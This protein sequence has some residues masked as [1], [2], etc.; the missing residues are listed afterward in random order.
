MD[1]FNISN[2]DLYNGLINAR[3]LIYDMQV[4]TRQENDLLDENKILTSKASFAKD[5]KDL[6][7]NTPGKI[8]IFIY[9]LFAATTL[10]SDHTLVYKITTV[11]LNG[12][13]IFA[14]LATYLYL[15]KGKVSKASTSFELS[16]MRSNQIKSE[17]DDLYSKKMRISNLFMENY[18]NKW[19]PVQ[20]AYVD[21][22]DKFI[23]YLDSGEASTVGEMVSTYKRDVHYNNVETQ[24]NKMIQQQM[25]GNVINTANLF[26]NLYTASK[27][28][29]IND[30]IENIRESVRNNAQN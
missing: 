6:K 12:L 15:K 30:N 19:Y 13:F 29:N 9:L 16:K 27:T 1:R 24:N 20:Y 2:H 26:T 11:S 4:I 17:L 7:L 22:V 25:I 21:A 28:K 8:I 23:E 18:G 10:F 5:K 3:K 14:I